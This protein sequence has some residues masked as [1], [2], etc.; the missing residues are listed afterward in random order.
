MTVD[1][2]AQTAELT[3]RNKTAA[4]RV[5]ELVAIARMRSLGEVLD[6]SVGGQRDL[7]S[8]T[9]NQ[10][11]NETTG[12]G[13]GLILG[14][15][16]ASG[17]LGFHFFARSN[18][19]WIRHGRGART[20]ITHGMASESSNERFET[21]RG[22]ERSARS[23]RQL[24]IL[25]EFVLPSMTSGGSVSRS[26]GNHEGSLWRVTHAVGTRHKLIPRINE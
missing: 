2:L 16:Q 20:N 8:S 24:E 6:A 1:K 21:R 11:W 26:R 18:N 22:Q 10:S 15:Q 4:A 17:M 7:H 13:G 25:Q 5:G 12:S 14:D 3:V 19:C 9:A 23:A